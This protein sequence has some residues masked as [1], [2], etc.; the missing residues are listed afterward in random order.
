M[1][2]K[3]IISKQIALRLLVFITLAAG[4]VIFDL[5]HDQLP[6]QLVKHQQDASEPQVDMSPTY[7]CNPASSFKIRMGCDRLVSKILFTIGQ[8]RF[9]TAFHNQEA[10]HLLKAESLKERSPQNLM[11]HFR[12]FIICHHS[13]SDDNAPIA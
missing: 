12:K 3:R 11:V 4:A 2:L 6:E 7:F 8:D 13:S 5:C 10:Y 1:K 9:L